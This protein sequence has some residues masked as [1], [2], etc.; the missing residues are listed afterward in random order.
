[1]PV[2]ML[3]RSGTTESPLRTYRHQPKRAR[4]RIALPFLHQYAPPVRGG[5][6]APAFTS[7]ASG[8]PRT[9]RIAG[10]AALPT[11][12]TNAWLRFDATRKALRIAQPNSVLEIGVGVGGL[13]S[14]LSRRYAY[15]GVE[16]DD[17]SRSA[18]EARISANGHGE[19]KA[20]LADVVARDFDLAG[21][22]EVLEHIADDENALRQWRGY[23]RPAGWLLL[24]VPAH[25]GDYGAADELA[26]HCRRYDRDRLRRLLGDAG[27]EVVQFSSYGT[28]LGHALQRVRN[29]LARRALARRRDEGETLE[30][31]TSRSGRLFF[32]P[33]A[34]REHARVRDRGRSGPLGASALRPKRSR[35]RLRRARAPFRVTAQIPAAASASGNVT[36][37]RVASRAMQAL[38][39]YAR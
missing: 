24:S 26:G 4:H 36:F 30:A 33:R 3:E 17:R 29:L 20:Q 27:F 9:D 32:Q 23:L 35:H 18:A 39:L 22:F 34:R 12:T 31:R 8:L 14:W 21:A 13:G 6:R 5:V 11:L 16:I 7:S 15:T 1:M 2:P 10:L 37:G 25:Q 38:G 28:G 19:I